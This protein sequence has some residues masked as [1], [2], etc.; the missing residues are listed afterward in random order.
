V[1]SSTIQITPVAGEIIAGASVSATDIRTPPVTNGSGGTLSKSAAVY[2]T[3]AGEW[4]LAR[5][6]DATT[7]TVSGLLANAVADGKAERA[8][9]SGFVGAYLLDA[10]SPADPANGVKLYLSN[11]EAGKLTSV[12]PN[13][14]GEFIVFVGRVA[15]GGLLLEVDVP[16]AI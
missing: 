15:P 12:A 13:G 11:T 5:A 8:I 2:V 4:D 9:F 1:S 14:V 3:A 7:H 16:I 6:D 10:A